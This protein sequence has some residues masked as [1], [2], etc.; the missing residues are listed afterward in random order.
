MNINTTIHY[1]HFFSKFIHS[2]V[3]TRSRDLAWTALS[4]AE[5]TG[6]EIVLI[7]TQS[8][9]ARR[10]QSPKS[11]ETGPGCPGGLLRPSPQRHR[12]CCVP[13]GPHQPLRARL[14]PAP[15]V[16][17]LLM[18]EKKVVNSFQ[19]GHSESEKWESF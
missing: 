15:H 11:P 13:K 5:E 14:D 8:R 10:L 1:D 18:Q 12:P 3:K 7:A 17:G 4:G 6:A 16:R 19:E 2:Q 9:R